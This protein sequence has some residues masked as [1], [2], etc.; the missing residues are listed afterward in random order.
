MEACSPVL[1]E[2]EDVPRYECFAS[3]R[4][5]WAMAVE[6]EFEGT[7]DLRTTHQVLGAILATHD[8]EHPQPRERPVRNATPKFKGGLGMGGQR[9]TSLGPSQTEGL[10]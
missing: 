8:L 6:Y 7:P 1:V 3:G 9:I 10:G 5:P 2:A 4:E